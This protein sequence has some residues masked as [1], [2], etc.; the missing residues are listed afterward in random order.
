MDIMLRLIFDYE[1][2]LYELPSKIIFYLN[3]INSNVNK[4]YGG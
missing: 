4:T 3:K 2:K 1:I